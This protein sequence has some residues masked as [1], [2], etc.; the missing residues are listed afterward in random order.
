M[1]DDIFE[2]KDTEINVEEIMNEIRKRIK[3]RNIKEIEIPELTSLSLS[4]GINI[5]NEA[6]FNMDE[7]EK[8]IAYNNIGWNV[9]T[10]FPITSHRKIIGRYIVIGKKIIRKLLRWYI[11]PI[12][13]LQREFN[14][15]V[16]RALNQIKNFILE[17]QSKYEQSNEQILL[18]KQHIA[19]I[20]E[21]LNSKYKS[22]IIN[23]ELKKI[24]EELNK[25]YKLHEEIEKINEE[26]GKITQLNK[27]IDIKTICNKIYNLEELNY[28]IKE[29]EHNITSLSQQQEKINELK[30]FD[31]QIENVLNDFQKRLYI[32]EENVR[33]LNDINKKNLNVNL[34]V[35]DRLR[36][37][38]SSLKNQGMINNNRVNL[39]KQT[40]NNE[41]N[42]A[43]IDY[44]L[45]ETLYR[46]DR[47]EI[48]KRQSI[49]LKYFKDKEVILDIGCGKGEFIELLIQEGKKQ[50]KGIDINQ[51][52]ILYCKDKGLPVEMADG[53]EYL[54]NNV[55][56]D[57]LDGIFMGQVIEHMTPRDI[58]S[59]TRLLYQKLKKNGVIVIET[60][61][62]QCLYVF[63]H[64]FYLDISHI[65]PIHPFTLQFILQSEGFEQIDILYLSKTEEKI[66]VIKS[67]SIENLEEINTAIE[68]L[69][70]LIY[71][72]QDYAIIA[73]K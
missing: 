69:N 67:N 43:D 18:L 2:I 45:F 72:S 50:V 19:S 63:A 33:G 38:E 41:E 29:L 30:K 65:K 10:E 3:E 54:K 20:K 53:I 17:F 37:I 6:N 48:K 58:I 52:M 16:T 40:E 70:N 73:K 21:D 71:G 15:S 5:N 32:V 60:V 14:A 4:E 26:L 42:F 46:G 56:D 49:Y 57:T 13:D 28:K 62:P 12:I 22:M 64:S 7:F 44:F 47:E 55:D 23:E 8:S 24:N 59:I 1:M 68:R 66:P 27:D 35:G 39:K 25:I 31:F 51:D 61:N 11:N 36:R 9:E 34:T